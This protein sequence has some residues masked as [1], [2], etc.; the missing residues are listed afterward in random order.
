VSGSESLKVS[1]GRSQS[2]GPAE[3]AGGR[4][5]KLAPREGEQPEGTRRARFSSTETSEDSVFGF[6][7]CR[8]RSFAGYTRELLEE[9]VEGVASLKVVQEV[10]KR[11]TSATENRLAAK[12]IWILDNN[13]VGVTRHT[14]LLTKVNYLI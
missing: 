2:L 1:W 13:G 6:F 7:Q 12:D 5:H 3:F 4:P 14:K 9:I 10:L 11:D 8:D